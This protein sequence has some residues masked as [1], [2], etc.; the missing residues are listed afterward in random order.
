[1]LWICVEEL[2]LCGDCQV[3]LQAMKINKSAD[4]IGYEN[5]KLLSVALLG[6]FPIILLL[7][8]VLVVGGTTCQLT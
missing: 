5:H 7:L 1:M 6:I 4:C 8:L 3:I 2:K